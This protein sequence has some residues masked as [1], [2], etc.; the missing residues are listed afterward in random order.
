MNI[1]SNRNRSRVRAQEVLV[2][3]IATVSPHNSQAILIRR[4]L[5]RSVAI[6]EP[7]PPLHGQL[8]ADQGQAGHHHVVD[9]LQ[10]AR[11]P[12]HDHFAGSQERDEH[13]GRVG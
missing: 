12:V 6:G 1:R 13:R 11:R 5:H 4:S 8:L 9:G 3:P 10:R 7:A 2:P